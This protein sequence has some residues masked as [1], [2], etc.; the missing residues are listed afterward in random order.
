MKNKVLRVKMLS[1]RLKRISVEIDNRI[2]KR[3]EIKYEEQL[4]KR[5]KLQGAKLMKKAGRE[6]VRLLKN[7]S[8]VKKAQRWAYVEDEDGSLWFVSKPTLPS[9]DDLIAL[10]EEMDN[11]FF[12][13]TDGGVE[14][15]WVWGSNQTD[16]TFLLT[17]EQATNIIESI[18]KEDSD[19]SWHL[20]V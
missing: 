4:T 9:I 5:L 6:L 18:G 14:Y 16:F 12:V 1:H 13:M 17:P 3:D 20:F 19:L 7:H 15:N 11:H 8:L 2:D 10:G